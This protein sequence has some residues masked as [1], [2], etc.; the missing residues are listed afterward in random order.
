MKT[1]LT[2]RGYGNGELKFEDTTDF[3]D[4]S[5]EE[6][7]NQL[8]EKHG[9]ALLPYDRHM[10]EIEFHDEPDPLQR[11]FRYGTDT[12]RMENPVA[13]SPDDFMDCAENILNRTH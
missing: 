11:F 6:T 13:V 7:L 8:G 9:E 4:S 1:Q 10:I 5:L 12:R 3:D 2:I